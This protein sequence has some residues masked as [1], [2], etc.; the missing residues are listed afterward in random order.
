M[1]APACA[2]AR[3]LRHPQTL[4]P[5]RCA[6]AVC[7]TRFPPGFQRGSDVTGPAARSVRLIS[8]AAQQFV[9]DVAAE[10]ADVAMQRR[11]V[12]APPKPP[13]APTDKRAPVPRL[14]L[15]SEDLAQALAGR[16]VRVARPP[17]FVGDPPARR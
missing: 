12:V 6:V 14:V 9:R 2:A 15:T 11:G 10:A 5:L 8:L 1:R 7:K 4:A 17:Y 13:G 3:L 16:G